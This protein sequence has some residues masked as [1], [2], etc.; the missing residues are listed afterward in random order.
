[1]C[2]RDRGSGVGYVLA[3]QVVLEGQRKL[4]SEKVPGLSLIHI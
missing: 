3:V 1:M 4:D 2:I